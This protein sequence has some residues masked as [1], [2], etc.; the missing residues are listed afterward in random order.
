[1]TPR[2]ARLVGLTGLVACALSLAA[3]APLEIANGRYGGSGVVIVGDPDT[4]RVQAVL[5]TLGERISSPP[6]ANAGT[7]LV[8][9][10]CLL[11]VLVGVLIVSRQPRNWAGWTFIAVGCRSPLRSSCRPW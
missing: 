3:A 8:L 7:V 6:G 4:P 9:V 11:W 1:M 10:M 2:R 5:D